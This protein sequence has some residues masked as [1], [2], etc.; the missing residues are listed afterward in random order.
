MKFDNLNSVSGLLLRLTKT[1]LFRTQIAEQMRP[2]LV[3]MR[4]NVA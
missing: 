3:L 1:G 2:A 4:L